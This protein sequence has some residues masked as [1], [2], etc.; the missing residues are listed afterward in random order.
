MGNLEPRG[1]LG[2]RSERRIPLD[3]SF[4]HRGADR[5][6]ADRKA[7]D[8]QRKSCSLILGEEEFIE[9]HRHAANRG[10][11]YLAPT[12]FIRGLSRWRIAWCR[13]FST[14]IPRQTLWRPISTQGRTTPGM[15][16]S[17]PRFKPLITW[18]EQTPSTFPP[19]LINS[20][21]RG[22]GKTMPPPATSTL[23][24]T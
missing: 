17:G 20:P 22:P 23:R 1:C 8:P 11:H 2:G 7:P 13:R 10:G 24:T 5:A 21:F 19:G 12:D 9:S 15:S 14:L 16:L 6:K 18:V 4:N 3:S